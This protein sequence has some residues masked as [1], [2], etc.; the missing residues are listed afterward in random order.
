MFKVQQARFQLNVCIRFEYFVCEI[1]PD[2]GTTQKYIYKYTYQNSRPLVFHI[3]PHG[4]ECCSGSNS[5]LTMLPNSKIFQCC[6]SW[7]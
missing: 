5:D 1:R 2:G 7:L 3:P 6:M 4:H